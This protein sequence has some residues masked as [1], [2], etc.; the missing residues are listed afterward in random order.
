MFTWL[1]CFGFINKNLLKMATETFCGNRDLFVVESS[2]NVSPHAPVG[3][4]EKVELS[5]SGNGEKTR[6]ASLSVRFP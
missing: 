5:V 6:V 1:Y 3:K 2:S 4:M